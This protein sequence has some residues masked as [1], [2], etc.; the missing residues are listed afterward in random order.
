MT[1]EDKLITKHVK[2]INKCYERINELEEAV[3]KYGGHLKDCSFTWENDPPM[4]TTIIDL[5]CTCGYE[6]V[7][8]EK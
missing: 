5:R 4:G 6:K 3:E 7:L 2:T 8:E 1:P